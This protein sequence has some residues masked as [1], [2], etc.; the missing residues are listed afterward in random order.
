[1]ED[2]HPSPPLM[3]VAS[4][5]R[6]TKGATAGRECR[7]WR[8]EWGADG[9]GCSAPRP[10]RLHPLRHHHPTARIVQPPAG[11]GSSKSDPPTMQPPA[12]TSLSPPTRRGAT[13]PTWPQPAGASG[14]L[15]RRPPS[16]RGTDASAAASSRIAATLHPSPSATTS[17]LLP[18]AAEPPP[19]RAG[20]TA[21]P[22]SVT[23]SR[24]DAG[25]RHASHR[26]GSR[27]GERRPS[28]R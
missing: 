4:R 13:S 14:T 15:G 2:A 3:S 18:A 12:T 9:N 11:R 24:G 27:R 20:A 23:L 7:P 28:R 25:P 5:L 6:G 1:M 22:R 8:R 26:E 17:R 19:R 16:N 10:R 21:L